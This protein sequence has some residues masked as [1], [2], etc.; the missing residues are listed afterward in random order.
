MKDFLAV[1]VFNITHILMSRKRFLDVVTKHFFL[2]GRNFLLCTRI[3]FSRCKN[4]F[5][6]RK[7]K[8]LSPYQEIIFLESEIIFV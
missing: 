8:V 6:G 7:K 4:F 3:L 5:C 1:C 2:V